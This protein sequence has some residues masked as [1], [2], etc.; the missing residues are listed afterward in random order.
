MKRSSLQIKGIE[1]EESQNKDI[2]DISN[3]VIEERLSRCKQH[4]EHQIRS[5]RNFP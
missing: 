2:E 1:E 3:K 4:A 5:K